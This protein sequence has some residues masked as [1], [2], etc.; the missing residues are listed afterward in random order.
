MEKQL[1]RLL[2][3]MFY[4]EFEYEF[5]LE[6]KSD[7]YILYLNNREEFFRIAIK[8]I[9]VE[10]PFVRLH[11]QNFDFLDKYSPNVI[12]C[13]KEIIN[14]SNDNLEYDEMKKF[15]IDTL[16]ELEELY[17]IVDGSQLP[18][19]PLSVIRPSL[20]SLSKEYIMKKAGTYFE[21]LHDKVING[22]NN[23]DTK[24]CF[25]FEDGSSKTFNLD[26]T[27]LEEFQYF[28]L[29]LSSNFKQDVIN[30][31]VKNEQVCLELIKFLYTGI[32]DNNPVL[33]I[34]LFEIGNYLMLNDLIELCEMI[35]KNEDINI[36]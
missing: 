21:K 23:R 1:D 29:V 20:K 4:D 34:E 7:V 12:F 26:S 11:T 6:N 33:A 22:K 25:K 30:I 3:K 16:E 8:H 5:G 18:L 32:I 27:I 36:Y 13:V 17:D 14:L 10:Q 2:T 24:V 19:I 15:N 35:F 31:E 28:N 9:L